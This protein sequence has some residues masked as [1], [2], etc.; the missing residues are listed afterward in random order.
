MRFHWA[1][2]GLI[3]K[4]DGSISWM[5]SHAQGPCPIIWQGK[6]K[7]FFASRPANN[8]TLPGFVELDMNNPSKI[9]YTH[10]LPILELGG[11]GTFDEHGII[12]HPPIEVD[13]RLYL[14]Y[15]GWSRRANTPYSLSLG[16]SI[17]DDGVNFKKY[18]D[19]PVLGIEKGDGLSVTAP[20][21]IYHE[22]LFYMFYTAGLKWIMINNRW[23]HTYTIRLAKSKDGIEW[24]RNYKN[25]LEPQN[26]YE[27]LS[28]PT[29]VKIGNEFHMWFSYKG[30]L[31][32]RTGADSYRLGYA[33]S[34]DL[35]HW[36]RKDELAGIS[37]SDNKDDWDSQMIEYSKIIKI[38][39]RYLL[40]Y[41]GNGFSES[42]F[43]YAELVTNN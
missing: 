43:G 25:I 14:Y 28:A 26:D 2:K 41:N 8:L 38:D 33:V 5:R 10:P 30:S 29:I 3:F 18:S 7:V 20:G 12:P 35:L 32:F 6:L 24:T 37:V 17:S 21:I 9:L 27:C 42:G 15:I 1:K 16:L 39:N 34:N 13:G 23:E 19:G 36:Q 31:D 22:G 40:F 4:P 11:P